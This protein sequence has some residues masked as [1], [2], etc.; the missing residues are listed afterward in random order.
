MRKKR[1]EKGQ[2]HTTHA[3]TD[4]PALLCACSFVS[5]AVSCNNMR[6]LLPN[7]EGKQADP[8]FTPVASTSTENEAAGLAAPSEQHLPVPAARSANAPQQHS[9]AVPR[10]ASTEVQPSRTNGKQR[11]ATA[12]R[13]GVSGSEPSIDN[14]GLERNVKDDGRDVDGKSSTAEGSRAAAGTSACDVA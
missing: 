4:R 8:P 10:E 3:T 6:V 9:R 13:P 11:P 7:S 1:E 14:V 2:H 12:A 5:T